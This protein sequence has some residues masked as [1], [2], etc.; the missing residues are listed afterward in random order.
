MQIVIKKKKAKKFLIVI[1]AL[2]V[3]IFVYSQKDIF[4]ADGDITM[5]AQVITPGRNPQTGEIKEFP[6]PCD[7]PKGWDVLEVGGGQEIIRNGVTSK[8]Y[9]NSDLGLSFEYIINPDGY[10]LVQ[11]KKREGDHEDL[12][13]YFAIR[14]TKEQEAFLVSKVPREGPVEIS[15]HVFNNVKKVDI[16]TWLNDNTQITNYNKELYPIAKENVGGVEALEFLSDGVYL[17]R[18][19]LLESN[20]LIYFVSGPEDESFG[21]IKNDFMTFLQSIVVF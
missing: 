10:T 1:I 13:T 9:W 12:V 16:F 14:N 18:N 20:G 2:G 5:C 19:Y 17:K 8:V 7:V 15:I 3:T 21:N 11:H 4:F 6:T